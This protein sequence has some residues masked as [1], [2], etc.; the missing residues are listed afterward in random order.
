MILEVNKNETNESPSDGVVIITPDGDDNNWMFRVSLTKTQSIVG[1]RKFTT[2][3][4]GFAVED[5]RAYVDLPYIMPAHDIFNHI[6]INKGDDDISDEAC[7]EAIKVI[8]AGVTRFRADW[9]I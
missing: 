1:F 5:E 3:G 9:S 2:I 6:K 4:I 8:Q 7:I